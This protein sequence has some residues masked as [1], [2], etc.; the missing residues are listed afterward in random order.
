MDLLNI[1]SVPYFSK[2]NLKT[3]ITETSNE[4]KIILYKFISPDACYY[5][6]IL[7]Y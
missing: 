5:A 1:I 3:F 2:S 6:N 4:Q 7:Y